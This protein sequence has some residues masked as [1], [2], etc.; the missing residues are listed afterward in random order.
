MENQVREFY[1]A[2]KKVLLVKR[3]SDKPN[4]IRDS[5]LVSILKVKFYWNAINFIY[6]DTMEMF[7]FFYSHIH[8][9]IDDLGVRLAPLMIDMNP[10]VLLQV[11]L[12]RRVPYIWKLSIG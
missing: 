11:P 10:H 1:K 8:W 3:R 6:G 7:H 5:V 2:Y 4:Y 9:N 12:L